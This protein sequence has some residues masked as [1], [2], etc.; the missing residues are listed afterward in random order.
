MSTSE[1]IQFPRGSLVS[2]QSQL[3]TQLWK[4]T[5]FD[6]QGDEISP[7]LEL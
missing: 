5:I 2:R 3:K 4:S 6:G 1:K 7:P